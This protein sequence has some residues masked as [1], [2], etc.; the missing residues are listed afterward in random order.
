MFNLA[1][2]IKKINGT[3]S[4][5]TTSFCTHEPMFLRERRL[6]TESRVDYAI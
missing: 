5:C 3:T 1:E 2:S 4:F 6:R